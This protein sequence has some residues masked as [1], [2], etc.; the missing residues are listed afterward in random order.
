MNQ[1]GYQDLLNSSTSSSDQSIIYNLILPNL[2]PNSVPYIDST[3]T[4]QDRI[5]LNGQLLIG[6][7]AGAPVAASITGT[8]DEIIVT[9]GPGT[10]TLSTPQ[11]IAT[12]SSPTFSNITIT[13]NVAGPINTRTADNIV[14]NTSTGVLNNLASFVS[15]KVIKDSG[16][17]ALT[18]PWLPLAG[19][20]MNAVTGT[21]DLNDNSLTHVSSITSPILDSNIKIGTVITSGLINGNN[22][23]IGKTMNIAAGSVSNVAIGAVATTTG[24]SGIAIGRLAVAG[25]AGTSVGDQS[26]SA[27]RGTALGP[28]ARAN[29]TS[30]VALGDNANNTVANTVL[31]GSTSVSNIRPNSTN[32]DLGTTAAKYK[33]IYCSGNLIGTVKTSAINDLV[34]NAGTSTTNNITVFADGTGKVISTGTSAIGTIGAIT[35]ANTTDSSSVTTGT[36]ICPGGIGVA[37]KLFVGSNAVIGVATPVTQEN[38]LTLTGTNSSTAGPHMSSYTDFDIYPLSQLLNWQHDNVALS[39]DGYY[40]GSWRSSHAGSNFQINKLASHFEF[41]YSSGVAAGSPITWVNAGYIDTAGIMQ[42]QKAINT[43]DS[44][45]SSSITT[46]SLVAAGGLG[47]SGAANI[48]GVIKTTDATDSSSTTTG[49]IITAGG[50]GVAK[51]IVAGGVIKTTDATDSSSTT[52]GSIITAGGIGVAKSIVVGANTTAVT[53]ISQFTDADKYMLLNSTNAAKIAHASGWTFEQSS[54]A[55]TSAGGAGNIGVYKW[56][57]VDATGAAWRTVMNLNN[58]GDLNLTST[59]DSSSVSTGSINTAGGIGCS[60]AITAGGIIKT[61]DTTDSTTTTTGSI[62]GAGGLGV[63]KAITAGGRIKTTDSTASTTSVT[64]SGIFGGGIGVAGAINAGTNIGGDYIY[65]TDRGGA[66]EK[67]LS[68]YYGTGT[69]SSITSYQQS[70]GDRDLQLS[71][72]NL[73]IGTVAISAAG[74]S[75]VIFIGNRTTGPTGGVSPVGGGILYCESGKLLYKGTSG[76]IT[77]LALA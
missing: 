25:D 45:A 8:T 10:I 23:A 71:M 57:T 3:N 60:K 48:G 32:C 56:R 61:T 14:S 9:N 36:L 26:I 2:D 34:T 64:G 70:V 5:L 50:I 30:C 29:A 42:W 53:R 55:F 52:T 11:P 33:D 15:D 39:F 76:T 12:T 46:G 59:T 58:V 17:S 38:R 49:S 67:T 51:S 66:S 35:L 74:G 44:T 6:V 65:A 21:I 27:T 75:G 41:N 22:I 77:T 28:D 54:G 69:I 19:G 20:T 72:K 40:N 18:G 1:S 73:C 4:V 31:I 43:A 7:T 24:N 47:I 16:V 68:L 13:N 63:V 37:K 62:Q